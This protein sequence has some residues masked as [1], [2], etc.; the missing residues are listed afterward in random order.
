[1]IIF[2]IQGLSMTKDITLST[3]ATIAL[4]TIIGCGGSGGS[5]DNTKTGTGY[6]VDSAVEGVEYTCGNQTGITD[7]DGKFAFEEGQGCNFTLDG[8][9]LRTVKADELANGKEVFEDNLTVAKLLQ[10]IDAD[11]N[12]DNGIQITVE[13]AKALKKALEKEDC[14]GK[15]PK[16]D[17][18]TEVVADVG[19]DVEHVSGD[20][21]TDE[22]V[23]EH[24]NRTH[25]KHDVEHEEIREDQNSTHLGHDVEHEEVRE[26]QNSTH[27]GHDVEHSN[28]DDNSENHQKDSHDD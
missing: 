27:L 19:H 13:V 8:I 15:L 25:V 16:G 5:S 23:R 3:I 4:F 2:N 26:D 12:P 9:T 7:K 21:R 20:L 28:S 10:S 6:Y 11:G 1:L 14:K 24:W 22:E 18:L 17:K